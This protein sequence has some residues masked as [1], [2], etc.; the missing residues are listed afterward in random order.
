MS[1]NATNPAELFGGT[2][3]QIKGR[4]LL[5]VGPND[6][7]TTDWW[8]SEPEGRVN[9]PAGELGGESW[10]TLTVDQMPSHTHQAYADDNYSGSRVGN[11]NPWKQSLINSS[12]SKCVGTNNI[13]EAHV[14]CQAIDN[15]YIT[16]VFNLDTGETYELRVKKNGLLLG[17]KNVSGA[18]T[19]LWSIF[20]D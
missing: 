4:F 13:K 20:C 8:G 14:D 11:T 10:H 16:F 12:L 17:Y 9:A 18:W 7:N 6:A 15:R 2:W 19:D 1:V 5:G 3:E